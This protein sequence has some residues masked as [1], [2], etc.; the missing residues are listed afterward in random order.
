MILRF[1]KAIGER[2]RELQDE[3]VRQYCAK[4]RALLDPVIPFYLT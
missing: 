3:A 1:D 4:I 2:F